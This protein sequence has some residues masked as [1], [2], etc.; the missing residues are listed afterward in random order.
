MCFLARHLF[1]CI[2]SARP[3]SPTKR[4]LMVL[5]KY[6]IALPRLESTTE[7]DVEK[8]EEEVKGNIYIYI[9]TSSGASCDDMFTS[10]FVLARSVLRLSA[11]R[12]LSIYVR[13]HWNIYYA[14]T[15]SWRRLN[16]LD[17]HAHSMW[18][19]VCVCIWVCDYEID[20]LVV[21]LKRV[22]R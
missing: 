20:V 4:P 9:C 17:A 1:N 12:L 7:S 5:T 10:R 19:C 13:M 11:R 22:N 21:L 8:E 18:T 2:R 16:E 6:A 14:P 3:S 15:A